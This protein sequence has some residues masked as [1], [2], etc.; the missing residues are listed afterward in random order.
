[1]ETRHRNHDPELLG[2]KKINLSFEPKV[3]G[4]LNNNQ[5]LIRVT[6]ILEWE[7]GVVEAL[8]QSS[9]LSRWLKEIVNP[10]LKPK[11]E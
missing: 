1:M 5:L 11:Q 4:P 6:I 2:L 8:K 9:K 3:I 10:A 7:L